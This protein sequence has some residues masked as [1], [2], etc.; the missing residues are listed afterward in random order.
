MAGMLGNWGRLDVGGPIDHDTPVSDPP[1]TCSTLEAVEIADAQNGLSLAV[2]A[3]VERKCVRFDVGGDVI[4]ELDER[5][6]REVCERSEPRE[7]LGEANH[8]LLDRSAEVPMVV[9]CARVVG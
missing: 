6:A 4:G 3:A 8:E 9:M 5:V 7:G 1:F 2:E